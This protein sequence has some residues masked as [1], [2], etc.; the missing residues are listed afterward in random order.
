MSP[1]FYYLLYV[2]IDACDENVWHLW[3]ERVLDYMETHPEVEFDAH[4]IIAIQEMIKAS[5]HTLQVI[6]IVRMI[7][8][9]TEVQRF[10]R[11]AAISILCAAVQHPTN[12]QLRYWSVKALW[13]AK[14]KEALPILRMRDVVELDLQTQNILQRAIPILED[15]EPV[16]ARSDQWGIGATTLLETFAELKDGFDGG[17]Q[18]PNA[19]TLRRARKFV[20]LL[21]Q[22]NIKPHHITPIADGGVVFVFSTVMEP[23]RVAFCNDDLETTLMEELV[24]KVVTQTG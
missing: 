12:S 2:A 6:T 9:L 4:D 3:P 13:Q 20:K 15:G 21:T 18:A 7:G 11:T 14:L 5:K 22:H 24:P 10:D 16:D 19:E 17:G 23:S 8:M 1:W